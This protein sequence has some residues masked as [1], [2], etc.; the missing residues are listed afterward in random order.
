MLSKTWMNTVRELTVFLN[1]YESHPGR[2]CTF[3]IG[4]H[5][6]F[7]LLSL[8]LE[9]SNQGT[10]RNNTNMARNSEGWRPLRKSRLG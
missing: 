2:Y 10:K 4:F 9:R 7:W 1:E 5:F 8:L 3:K 6:C